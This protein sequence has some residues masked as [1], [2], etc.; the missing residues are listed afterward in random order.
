MKTENEFNALLSKKLKSMSPHIHYIKASDKFTIGVSDFIIWGGGGN[1]LVMESK[2]VKEIPGPNAKLLKHPFSGS[3]KTFLESVALTK[4]QAFGLVGVHSWKE[5]YLIPQPLVKCNWTV[6]EFQ[7]LI[8]NPEV[9]SV[10]FGNILKL[11]LR[12]WV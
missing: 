11:L 12:L 3:Q 10:D 7:E 5:M 4:N 6:S 2:F 8:K 1:S 9:E